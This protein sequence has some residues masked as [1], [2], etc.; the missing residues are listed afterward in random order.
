MVVEVG[1][2][3]QIVVFFRPVFCKWFYNL[4]FLSTVHEFLTLKWCIDWMYVCECIDVSKKWSIISLACTIDDQY[5]KYISNCFEMYW[6]SVHAFNLFNEF[7]FNWTNTTNYKMNI[8]YHYVLPLSLLSLAL[9]YHCK[10]S[11]RPHHY[12]WNNNI[13]FI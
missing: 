7:N 6:A 1:Y 9:P 4:N 11:H 10:G 8:N 2:Y 5:S 12:M 3:V 13:I